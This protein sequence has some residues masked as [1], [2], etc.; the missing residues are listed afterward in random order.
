[1]L[2]RVSVTETLRFLL[3]VTAGLAAATGAMFT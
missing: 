1:M 2:P 3:I